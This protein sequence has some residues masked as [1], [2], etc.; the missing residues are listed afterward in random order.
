MVLE[1]FQNYSRIPLPS[2]KISI[3]ELDEYQKKCYQDLYFIL[4]P[5]Y[6]SWYFPT[7]PFK[8]FVRVAGGS[9]ILQEFQ[10]EFRSKKHPASPIDSYNEKKSP[11]ITKK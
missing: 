7:F 4:L 1:F 8:N 5:I 11:S 10:S 3:E 9:R 2:D 6:I